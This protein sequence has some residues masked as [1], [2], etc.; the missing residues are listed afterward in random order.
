MHIIPCFINFFFYIW[1]EPLDLLHIQN[2]SFSILPRQF[3]EL[4]I[5]GKGYREMFYFA[6]VILFANWR[7]G[8]E[9]GRDKNER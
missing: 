4:Y 7:R 9:I 8:G 5:V 3:F 1:L 6:L 2:A